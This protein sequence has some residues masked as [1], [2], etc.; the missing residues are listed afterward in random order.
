MTSFPDYFISGGGQLLSLATVAVIW[1]TFAALGALI[2][3]RDR[4][5]DVDPLFGWA[6]VCLV[7]T[8]M[9]VFTALTF[10]VIAMALGGT[11]AA[12]AVIVIRRDG[13]LLSAGAVKIILLGAPLFL[14]VSAMA[15]SQWDEFSHWLPSIRF[16][17]ESDGFPARNNV[18][19]GGSFPA[20]P[21]NWPLASYLAGR[22][23]GGLIE[24]TGG[25]FNI[26][27]LFTFGLL[28][29]RLIRGILNLDQDAVPGWGLVALGGLAAT[30]FNP[31]FTQKVVLTAYADTSSA[32][33]LGA[34][35]VLGWFMLEAL[36]GGRAK[37]A[38][39]LSWQAG[40]MLMLLIN[41]KQANLVLCVILIGSLVLVA[42]RDPDIHIKES[43]KLLAG[44]IL[45]PL[46]IYAAW[47]YHVA[48]ELSGQEFRFRPFADWHLA[49][50]PQV[51]WK[52]L[53]V[54][55]KK[56]L[57]LGIMVLATLFAIRGLIRFRTGF[58]RMAI[59]AGFAF[60]GYNAFLFLTYIASFG[61]NDALRAASLWR[62][63]MHLGLIAV[64]F[65]AYG[66]A[67][68]WRT[69][70]APRMPEKPLAWISVLLIL[71]VPVIFAKKIRFDLEE[72]KPHYRAVAVKLDSILPEGSRFFVLDPRGNGESGIITR[73]DLGPSRTFVGKLA[74]FDAISTELIR[75][76]FKS[77]FDYLLVHSI[78]PSVIEALDLPLK[79]RT[80]YLLVRD[81][82]AWRITNS[83]PYP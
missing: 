62:Y 36:A 83:W 9:G 64:A 73:F 21:Y 23:G 53:T 48:T 68:L 6:L 10:T 30:L 4:V 80:S 32:V 17:L 65:A 39:R 55:A 22:L 7:F 26:L 58:D 43:W 18:F 41:L 77:K 74:A 51:L 20:Y 25:I 49:I 44:L 34:A 66:L 5:R 72:P 70:L 27:L 54:L 69:K 59:I 31:T 61:P 2:A 1:L 14:M 52:M 3:G 42:L 19:T 12:A 28:I 71:I 29:V 56:G 16:L 81:G 24:N 8:L 75:T 78:S 67:M 35:A 60:I 38:Y 37:E 50:I 40:L 57:Y 13:G 82:T 46:V 47:R 63:N 79:E 11:A 76:V 33:A 15:A 45:P